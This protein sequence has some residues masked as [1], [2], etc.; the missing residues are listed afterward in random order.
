MHIPNLVYLRSGLKAQT[1]LH[2][3][4]IWNLRQVISYIHVLLGSHPNSGPSCFLA[5]FTSIT[6][7][8]CSG[9][10]SSPS[11]FPCLLPLSGMHS[12]FQVPWRVKLL[13]ALHFF[14]NES[15]LSSK[16]TFPLKC[17]QGEAAF[18]LSPIARAWGPR[19]LP[20][21]FCL[22]NVHWVSTWF[23][24]LSGAWNIGVS[25][26]SALQEACMLVGRQMYIQYKMCCQKRFEEKD[27][28]ETIG[29]VGREDW[30]QVCKTAWGSS[31]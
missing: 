29:E 22:L 12:I 18:L 9:L 4:S 31:V 25:N 26:I 27:G 19:F 20:Y 30:L 23:Q 1:H 21:I 11:H 28:G 3:N 16:G 2:Q 14:I 17:S 15:W 8:Y 6:S 5:F 24:S 10:L 7:L 13:P